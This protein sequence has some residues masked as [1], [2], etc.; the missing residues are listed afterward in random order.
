MFSGINDVDRKSLI[1]AAICVGVTGG[2]YLFMR[3]A[4][5]FVMPILIGLAITLVIRK[6]VR[7]LCRR[8]HFPVTLS[9]V[10][11]LGLVMTVIILALTYVGGQFV[12]EFKKFMVHFDF[13]C[14][15]TMNCVCG[16]CCQVDEFLGLRDGKMY[17][18]LE[19]NVTNMVEGL[20]GNLLPSLVVRSA[21]MLESIFVVGGSF[22]IALTSVF[23]LMK[24]MDFLE[25]WVTR[26]RYA[27]WFHILFGRLAHFGVAYLRT[28]LVII[29]ITAVICILALFLIG[30]GY[31]VMIGIIIGLLD[32]LPLFGTGTVL[33][34][35][36]LI[37]VLGK[38]FYK[39][40]V[41]FTAYCICYIVREILEPKMM[42]GKMGIHPL[43]MLMMMYLGIVLFGILGFLLGPAAYIM[44][45]EIMKYVE[46]V[47]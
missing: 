15:Y 47:I 30:N 45:C 24:D 14:E 29:C 34:P 18:L 13:Y 26:G 5:S 42:G 36:T 28:Q 6:P 1:L 17:S 38:N 10:I 8:F 33:I 3:Y 20:T 2:V 7:F 21:G 46:K 25:E 39:A 22:L 37:Y 43:I 31:P 32:A 12:A 23:F 41:L 4:L 19:N 44:I 27:K 35:W 9:T 16:W 40:A 11:I